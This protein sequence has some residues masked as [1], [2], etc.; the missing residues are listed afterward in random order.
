MKFF[1]QR[2]KQ[3]RGKNTIKGIFD[4]NGTWCV[5]EGRMGEVVV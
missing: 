5:E 4:S 2:A 3:R 1:H